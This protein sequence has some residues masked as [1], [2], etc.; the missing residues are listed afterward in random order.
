MSN[1]LGRFKIMITGSL[2]LY[3]N[4]SVQYSQLI[5]S[6]LNG[7]VGS[8]FIV[9]NSPVPLRNDLFQHSRVFYFHSGSNLGFGSG[10]NRAIELIGGS[11]RFHLIL[12]P[13]VFFDKDVIPHLVSVMEDNQDIGALMPRVNNPD[14]SLQY[15]CKRLPTPIDL[16]IRRFI[17]IKLLHDY[18]NNRLELHDLP[19]DRL[20]DVPIIS[21]CFLLVRGD[22]FNTIGG[23][24]NRY[25]MYLEDV[26]LVRRI[27][28]LARV[29]YDPRVCITHAHE[30]GSYRNM[31]LLG[32]HIASAIKYFN[33]WGW[34]FDSTRRKRNAVMLR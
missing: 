18:A 16:I 17:P 30:K 1:Y 26:D 7:C 21:G 33:K 23:F 5:M 29:V 22:L 12:N 4:S 24:D 31:K 6:F 9:D 34:F 32:Y 13:D 11:S 27:G 15:L 14:G 20:V 19:Q 8:L 25:F 3:K 2:V 28:S 10:H